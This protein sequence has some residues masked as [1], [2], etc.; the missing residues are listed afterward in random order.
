MRPFQFQWFRFVGFPQIC[1]ALPNPNSQ[2]AH[3][4]GLRLWFNL[5]KFNREFACLLIAIANCYCYL[6]LQLLHAQLE[7]TNTVQQVN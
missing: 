4:R 3:P 7:N 2:C 5:I 1:V 6:N